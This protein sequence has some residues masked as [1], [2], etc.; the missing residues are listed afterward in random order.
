MI[1]GNDN[2]WNSTAVSYSKLFRTL[3]VRF[4]YATLPKRHIVS[5][6]FLLQEKL[7]IWTAPFASDLFSMSHRF[8]SR[9]RMH[10]IAGG[11]KGT[12]FILMTDISVFR[13]CVQRLF[14]DR[15]IIS[16]GWLLYTFF[17][18]SVPSWEYLIQ[19]LRQE[20]WSLSSYKARA[21]SWSSYGAF[22]KSDAS[23]G[24]WLK[25]QQMQNKWLLFTCI[26]HCT[27]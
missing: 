15:C 13:N 12:L 8:Q 27:C 25:K 26:R 14:T 6:G 9:I 4:Q 11:S 7:C 23:L 22:F 17:F 19:K 2:F 16:R 24:D 3:V 10:W 5:F 21:V 1:H 20:K 18:K